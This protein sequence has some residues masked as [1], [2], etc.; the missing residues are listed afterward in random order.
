MVLDM[1]IEHFTSKKN[2]PTVAVDG[3]LLHSKYDP[4]I[5]AQR[6]A[7]ANY[8]M[9]HTIILFGYG[10]GYVVDELLKKVVHEHIVI[11]DP[12]IEA[13]QLEI[14]ER[15]KNEKKVVYW[16]ESD[17]NTLG[18]TIAGLSDGLELKLTVICTPNYETL[19]QKEYFKLLRY[20]RDFQNKT[21]INNN[22][23]T[24]F[25]KQWQKNMAYNIPSIVRDKSLSA[26]QNRF[27][28]PIVIAS[29]GPSL[30]KQLPLLKKLE[31]HVIIIAAGSTIN[32][33]LA[34]N[35][36]PDFVVSIDGGEPNYN[37]FKDLKCENT[38]LIYST[39]NHHGIRQS[40]T[41]KAYV[42]AAM[43]QAVIRNYLHEKFDLDVPL[44][45]G[46]GTVA[47]FTYSI[48]HL[49]NS[50]PIAILGQDLAYTNNQT[51]AQNN[52]HTKKVDKLEEL[53][54]EL[55]KVEGYYGEDVVTSKSFNSMKM[56]FEEIMKFHIPEVPVYNCTEGGV[57][58]KGL[59]QMAF[60]EFADEYV[61]QNKLKDMSIL[62][63]ELSAKKT[64]QE[65]IE[66][67]KEEQNTIDK[68]EKVIE[69][70]LLTL[71]KNNS[72]TQFKQKTLKKL[73]RLDKKI[74]RLS[75]MVQIHFLVN[76]IT[77]EIEMLFLEQP[78]ETPEETYSRVYKQ[79]Y[80]LYERLLEA[81]KTSRDLNVEVIEKLKEE[82][83]ESN[84]GFNSGNN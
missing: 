42:F 79:S 61:D 45:L 38:R 35:I 84:D 56:T 68:L 17:T 3:L 82:S 40:F 59:P 75:K 1:K 13:G 20:L 65:I 74:E 69:E 31:E 55:I 16:Q 49:F 9:H 76:P 19:F 36:E 24:L 22:T 39:F 64:T 54:L 34:G 58:I 66:I 21:Q 77:L 26:L 7:Q 52:K 18:Y 15:H 51:H 43:G 2:I 27:E 14:A 28:L 37:H 78:N 81:I 71:E 11:I 63:E 12:L 57:K 62:D 70:A 72:K 46:G 29:G 30:T 4:V 83:E 80:T 41:K 32:S 23:V 67:L 5:E 10:L 44:I 8:S 47:H 33:L 73:D 50:G 60:Q 53:D 6:I 48:A 25:A